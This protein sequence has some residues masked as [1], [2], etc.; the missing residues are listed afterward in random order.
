[1]AHLILPDG[2]TQEIFPSGNRFTLSELQK[3]VGGY[4]E[5]IRLPDGSCLVV[6]E[7]G[8]PKCLAF[9]AQ[10]TLL[11]QLPGDDVVGPAVL[12]IAKE[13]QGVF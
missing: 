13:Q 11:A 5:R 6:D 1:M 2:T 7:E 12:L 10:A 9:N 3:L 8:K 4:I